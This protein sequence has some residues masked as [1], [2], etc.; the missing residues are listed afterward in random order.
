MTYLVGTL[1]V[2]E[3]VSEMYRGFPV[4]LLVL[5]V[6]VTYLFGI[7]TSNGTLERFVEGAAWLVRGRRALIPWIVFRRRVAAGDGGR[8]GIGRRGDAGATGASA[9]GAVRH[10]SPDGR[11]DGRA[12]RRGRQL[13]AAERPQRDRDSG[14]CDRTAC[15]CRRRCSSSRTSPTT[16]SW[17]ERSFWCLAACGWCGQNG[18]EVGRVTAGGGS[19]ARRTGRPPPDRS[20]LYARRPRGGGG[21]GVSIPAEYRL[22]C[23]GRRGGTSADLSQHRAAGADK[24]IAWSV[25]L[26]V[27]GIVTVCRGAPALRHG[28]RRREQHRRARQPAAH[29]AADLCGRGGHVGIRLERRHSRRDD[30][31]RRAVHGAG[32]SAPP[33]WSSRSRSRRRSSTRRRSPRLARWSSR[34][35][36]SR[37]SRGSTGAARLGRVMVLTAPFVT[38]LMFILPACLTP[39]LS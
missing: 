7:A 34:T 31:A 5:L 18:H 4:D 21:R 11:A 1:V 2:G 24:K 39:R 13:L 20:D 23:L 37:S 29:R 19:T 16:S 25:V 14:G 8:T 28:R 6:G 3:S 15:R 26:L 10:R 32:T 35:G 33:A 27:C 12:R 30:S 22:S 9:G 17:P 38:W 36:T